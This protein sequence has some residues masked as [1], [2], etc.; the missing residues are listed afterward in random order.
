MCAAFKERMTQREGYVWFLP[1]WFD[2]KWYDIDEL[3]II[4][5]RTDASKQ[6][7]ADKNLLDDPTPSMVHGGTIQMFED[8]EVGDL[9][10]CTTSQMLVAL[11]GHLSLVHPNF[12]KNERY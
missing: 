12:E 8:T 1:G 4:K 10:D 7:Q 3:R 5:N 2:D 9:P 6:L 11:D